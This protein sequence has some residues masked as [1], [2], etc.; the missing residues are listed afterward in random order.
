M[1]PI[2]IKGHERPLSQ[3]KFNRE[4][5][6]LFSAAR[7]RV[8]SVW[9]SDNGDRLG[10]LGPHNGAVFTIDVD[11]ETTF[12]VTGASDLN[13]RIWDVRTG[14]LMFTLQTQSTPRYVELSPDGKKLLVV[15][16]EQFKQIGSVKLFD[17]KTNDQGDVIIEENVTYPHPEDTAAFVRASWAYDQN[18]IVGAHQDGKVSRLNLKT[19][20]FDIKK[21]IHEQ[22]ITEL[23]MS[24][25]RSYF[26]T[27]SR[28]K[29]AHLMSVDEF[30]VKKTYRG[31]VPFNTAGITPGKN[32][33]LAGGGISARDVTLT[34]DNKFETHFFHKL[35]EDDLGRLGGHFGPINTIAIHPLGT[36]FASGS[37]DG[38]V[39]IQHFDK[40]YFEFEYH[41][42]PIAS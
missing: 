41:P 9:F 5:D 6:L 39:R 35:F 18:I 32:F 31:D 34:S 29:F 16:D 8:V 26:V 21:K 22:E 12:A 24:P 2:S 15:L 7:D 1:R 33:I 30:E 25:D 4:G 23:Q 28:D 17:L 13:L 38:Y 19:G 42:K 11:S 37:E 10:T 40:S 20:E 3:L 14:R 36:C 27:S